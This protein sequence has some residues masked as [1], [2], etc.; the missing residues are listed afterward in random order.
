MQPGW[1][2]T[3]VPL[4]ATH[5]REEARVPPKKKTQQ[6]EIPKQQLPTNWADAQR[7]LQ[8]IHQNAE[9][10]LRFIKP[11]KPTLSFWGDLNDISNPEHPA[12]QELTRLNSLGY[13]A[14]AVINKANPEAGVPDRI[15]KGDG[16]TRDEDILQANAVFVELDAAETVE[17]ENLDR[18][19]SCALPP[20]VIVQSSL[21]N[22]LHGIWP[23]SDDCNPDMFTRIQIQL[24]QL[25]N[26]DPV[27]K[28]PSRIM[29]M[30]GFWHTKK[31]PIQSR[32]IEDDNRTFAVNEIIGAFNLDPEYELYT[33]NRERDPNYTPPPGI[34][35]RILTAAKNRAAKVASSD[36]GRHNSLLWLAMSCNEN[37]VSQSD[38]TSLAVQLASMLPPRGSE[39][40]PAE[41]AVSAVDWAYAKGAGG[42]PWPD[43]PPGAVIT[44]LPGTVSTP[45]T[46]RHNAQEPAITG[47]SDGN[48]QQATP[49]SPAPDMDFLQPNARAPI[50]IQNGGYARVTEKTTRQGETLQTFDQLTNW[51]F[52]PTVTLTYPDR[53]LGMRGRL[54]INTREQYEIDLPAKAWAGRRELLNHIG[55]HNASMFSNSAADVSFIHQ[56]ILTNYPNLP[57]ATGTNTYGLL[58]HNN[59]WTLLFED[60]QNPELFYSGTPVDPGSPGFREPKL[61][62]LEQVEQAKLSIIDLPHL[63]TP[64]AGYAITGYAIASAFAP[65]ITPLLGDRIPF[66]FTTGERESGKSSSIEFALQMTSGNTSRLHKAPGMTTYQYDVAFSSNNNRLAAL[67]EYRPGSIDD[68]QLRKHHDLATKYRGSGLASKDHSYPLNC[69][70]IVSGEGFTEDAA[71]L[72]RGILYFI[73]KKHRGNPERYLAAQARPIWAFAHWLHYTAKNTS[74]EEHTARFEKARVLAKTVA[75]TRGGPRLQF[76][77]TFIAYGLLVAQQHIDANYYRD[78]VITRILEVGITQTLDGGSESKTNLETFLEQLGSAATEAKDPESVITPG[79]SH[80]EIIIRIS[81][82]VELVKRRYGPDAAIANP[83]LLRRYA[84]TVPWIADSDVHRDWANEVVRGLKVTLSEAV[85]SSDISALEYL[86][87]KIRA[88]R[89]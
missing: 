72:S 33:E 76:G 26:G 74:E 11:G 64:H 31:Q 57:I 70:L 65:R 9:T 75:G 38:A 16:S 66:L 62:T 22:K 6:R 39:P 60:T 35:A 28:N 2:R 13:G 49:S 32:L 54:T 83:R 46:P 50:T 82:A 61:S 63:I 80:G 55:G 51:V 53:T 8:L 17:G 71:A 5:L 3:P 30:P 41:E 69:P 78:E 20:S 44:G 1:R 79:R 56:F 40:I 58:K 4:S 37:N 24:A 84:E 10:E 52:T 15:A 45:E 21:I 48:E 88:N 81:P 18:L 77:L 68:A 85:A 89:R 67:D 12:L 34:T 87:A 59:Q 47:T 23:L 19:Q 36:V 43:P 86:E 27:C 29:R 42:S 7:Y 14:Y 73:E 25:F